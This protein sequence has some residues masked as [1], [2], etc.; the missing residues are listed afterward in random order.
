[1]LVLVAVT[2]SATA[3]QQG[4]CFPEQFEAVIGQVNGL[5]LATGQPIVQSNYVMLACDFTNNR[6][7]EEIYATTM[8]HTTSIKVIIDFKQVRLLRQRVHFVLFIFVV[9]SCC[10]D[11]NLS[12]NSIFF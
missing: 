8:G 2:A 1:M 10:L 9:L 7:G 12:F 5:V 11:Y 4:C 3:D 6:V